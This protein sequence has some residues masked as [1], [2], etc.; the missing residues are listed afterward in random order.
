MRRPAP[1]VDLA[2]ERRIRARIDELGE[3]LTRR[4]D[5]GDCNPDVAALARTVRTGELPAEALEERMAT[6]DAATQLRV[7]ADV[8]DR[9]DALIE[10]LARDPMLRAAGRGVS[11]AMVLRLAVLRGLD[12]LE[13]E[14]GGGRKGKRR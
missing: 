7:P 3:L 6:N 10:P 11:R 13:A 12:A 4:P 1:V 8:L 9:A 2:R 14:H 5:V